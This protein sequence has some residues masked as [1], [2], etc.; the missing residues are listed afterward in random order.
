MNTL[1]LIQ[2]IER[3]IELYIAMAKAITHGEGSGRITYVRKAVCAYV[4]YHGPVVTQR[5]MERF[6]SFVTKEYNK[7]VRAN[8]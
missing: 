6:W 2:A 3:L 7:E 4:G 1:E 5:T 8:Q